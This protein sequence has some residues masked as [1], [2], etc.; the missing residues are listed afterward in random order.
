RSD[1]LG[2][3]GLQLREQVGHRSHIRT[4][5]RL[6]DK[7]RRNVAGETQG[8]EGISVVPL[9]RWIAHRAVQVRCAG[10]KGA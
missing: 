5:V 7:I 2:V 1:E 3:G 9:A 10:T 6:T 4:L 8:A